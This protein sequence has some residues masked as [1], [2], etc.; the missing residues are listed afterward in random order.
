MHHGFGHV[1]EEKRA[2][3][4]GWLVLHYWGV[5]HNQKGLEI[6]FPFH[7]NHPKIHAVADVGVVG[8]S[9]SHVNMKVA[10]DYPVKHRAEHS[11]FSRGS[12]RQF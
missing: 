11:V 5:N 9:E 10:I 12:M 7:R 1:F 2:N 6:E 4:L 3:L 8:G